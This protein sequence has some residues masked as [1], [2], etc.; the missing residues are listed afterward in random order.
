MSERPWRIRERWSHT[1]TWVATS[2]FATSS[3]PGATTPAITSGDPNVQTQDLDIFKQAQAGVR[4]F[5]LRIAATKESSNSSAPVLL[6]AFH[7]DPKLM[8]NTEK[9][10]KD[11]FDLGGRKADVTTTKLP[12]EGAFGMRLPEMLCQ[13]CDFSSTTRVNF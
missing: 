12:L 1:T 3:S 10:K 5:D 9:K 8:V 6:K 2:G 13:A 7:A 11:I 4:V